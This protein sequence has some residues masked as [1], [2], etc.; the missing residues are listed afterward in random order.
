MT[1]A[2]WAFCFTFRC[3][4]YVTTLWAFY[5][6]FRWLVSLLYVATLWT[7]YVT[8]RWLVCWATHITCLLV[9]GVRLWTGVSHVDWGIM[10][11]ACHTTGTLLWFPARRR[12]VTNSRQVKMMPQLKYG[13]SLMMAT[14]YGRQMAQDKYKEKGTLRMIYGAY[15]NGHIATLNP[16]TV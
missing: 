8:F 5:V 10:W 12:H 9:R 6:T 14:E 4:L 11:H 1:I 13:S 15:L 16:N 7:F 2:L 3:L